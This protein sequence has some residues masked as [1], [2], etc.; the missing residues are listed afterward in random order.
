[1]DDFA[2]ETR[3]LL[4]FP[5]RDP[6]VFLTTRYDIPFTICGETNRVH[7]PA[8]TLYVDPPRCCWS[9]SRT[10]HLLLTEPTLRSFAEAP[11]QRLR[12]IPHLILNGLEYQPTL[13]PSYSYPQ[14]SDYRYHPYTLPQSYYHPPLQFSH[15][16]S[17]VMTDSNF[18]NITQNPPPPPQM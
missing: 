4:R 13:G 7:K 17:G 15:G 14:T 10:K 6:D 8:Y 18:N 12:I 16:A 9:W 5:E 2:R 1:M 3:T 11:N